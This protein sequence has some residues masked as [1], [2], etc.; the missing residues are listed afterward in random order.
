MLNIATPNG[1]RILNIENFMAKILNIEFLRS[2]ILNID[3]SVMISI[4]G[5]VASTTDAV[6]R[7][8]RFGRGTGAGKQERGSDK[9]PNKRT[10]KFPTLRVVLAA[11]A[12]SQVPSTRPSSSRS[13]LHSPGFTWVGS[14]GPS[15]AAV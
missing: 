5:V 12:P 9:R 15:A 4:F 1:N 10:F 13:S 7:R 8:P 6:R 11:Y 3:P 14:R 2:R